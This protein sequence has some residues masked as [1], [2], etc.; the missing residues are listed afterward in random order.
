MDE[1]R[2]RSNIKKEPTSHF[3]NKTILPESAELPTAKKYKHVRIT[4]DLYNELLELGRM[5]DSFGDLIER[6]A[7]F[8]KENHRHK[9]TS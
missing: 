1:E 4:E 3:K 2:F 9:T 6:L 7:K 8:W 5:G